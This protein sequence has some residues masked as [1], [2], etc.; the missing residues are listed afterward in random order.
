MFQI[1]SPFR[2]VVLKLLWL[3]GRITDVLLQ[4]YAIVK[5]ARVV[6]TFH[7]VPHEGVVHSLL[8]PVHQ[9]EAESEHKMVLTTKTD[10]SD[11]CKHYQS[12]NYD[13]I[14][15]SAEELNSVMH[16][17]LAHVKVSKTL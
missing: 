10:K 15:Q 17:N 12:M 9:C 14:D 13:K 1:L 8:D 11:V 2:D 5:V 4:H 7:K 16:F 6:K 3:L